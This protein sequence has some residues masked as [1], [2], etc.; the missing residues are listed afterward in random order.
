M[1]NQELPTHKQNKYTKTK[2]IIT[3]PKAPTNSESNLKIYP[4]VTSVMTS[5]FKGQ[6]QNEQKTEIDM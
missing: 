1:Q 6:K 4:T 2:E 5:H 3:K